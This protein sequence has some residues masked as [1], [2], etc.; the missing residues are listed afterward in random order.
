MAYFAY[1]RT[2]RDDPRALHDQIAEVHRA[3]EAQ[4]WDL[5]KSHVFADVSSGQRPLLHRLRGFDLGRAIGRGDTLIVPSIDRLGRKTFMV[6][7]LFD[8]W[9]RLKI[10]LYVVDLGQTITLAN[11]SA[12][13]LAG[14]FSD[15]AEGRPEIQFEP[16]E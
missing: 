1:V 3:A 4:G 10:K 11:P 6:A 16:S 2:D 12:A 13:L 7:A 9:A 15:P 8:V 5:P 14:Y